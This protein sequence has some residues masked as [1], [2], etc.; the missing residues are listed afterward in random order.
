MAVLSIVQ[1]R[2]V[3]AL[4]SSVS[5]SPRVT[6]LAFLSHGSVRFVIENARWTGATPG[7]AT[8]DVFCNLLV[9]KILGEDVDEIAVLS[10]D[11]PHHVFCKERLAL[12]RE[13][14][15]G[16]DSLVYV[17]DFPYVKPCRAA[18]FTHVYN[19][20]PMLAVWAEYY[21]KIV[22]P[23]NVYIIDHGS[24]DESLEA[25]K[26]P[27]QKI[28]VPRGELDHMNISKFC[29]HFQRFLLTQY[30][31][32]M[33]TDCDEFLVLAGN[34]G[35]LVEYIQ[36]FPA[37]STLKPGKAVELLHDPE[38]ESPIDMS[39]PITV[40]RKW[41]KENPH[42]EKPAISSKPTTWLAGFHE[43]CDERTSAEK[44][45]LVHSK[46]I[47]EGICLARNSRW[48]VL[49]Q[50]ELDKQVFQIQNIP[51]IHATPTELHQYLLESIEGAIQAPNWLA[52]RF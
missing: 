6:L 22:G 18:A 13:F 41:I 32:V 16:F 5:F 34:E 52:G 46:H 35:T 30:E 3:L 7:S 17:G 37:K 45:W 19:E 21:A 40:Q 33:H 9:D 12:S 24:T 10:L 50:T 31:W 49:K 14:R 47:D 8:L 44:I 48:N 42:Y 38:T 28:T 36:T 39:R 29:A 1:A 27:I 20:G 11:P 15:T 23:Q 4:E 26:A 2:P 43:C 25:I 51:F